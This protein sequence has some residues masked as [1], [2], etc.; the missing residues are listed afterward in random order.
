MSLRHLHRLACVCKRDIIKINY[1]RLQPDKIKYIPPTLAQIK[2]IS[3]YFT[4]GIIIKENFAKKTNSRWRLK[5]Q[6]ALKNQLFI[7]SAYSEIFSNFGT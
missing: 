7:S 1:R 3:L 4:Q 5:L 6:K 2:L